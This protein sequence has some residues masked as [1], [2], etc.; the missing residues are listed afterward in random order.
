MERITVITLTRGRPNL[1]LRAINSVHAQQCSVPI[2]HFI[3]IDDCEETRLMLS[4]KK[5]LPANLSWNFIARRQSDTS[6]PGRSAVIRNQYV[7]QQVNA[8][9]ISFL[10][11]DNEFEPNH[12]ESLL[13]CARKSG[14]RAVHS[15][16]KMFYPDGRPFIEERDPWTCDEE[17]ARIVYHAMVAKGVCVPGTNIFRDRAD[18]LDVSDPVRSVD[19]GEWLFTRQL[20][21]EIPFPEGYSE[22]DWYEMQT[23]DDKLLDRLIEFGEPIACSRQPTLKYYLGGYSNTRCFI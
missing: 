7:R 12:L 16:L 18:P 17:M 15:W 5:D 4:Q 13:L 14:C 8:T 3:A 22:K 19:T 6:G 9:W 11:D 1:L 10:D 2:D 21:M 23:E 20:L